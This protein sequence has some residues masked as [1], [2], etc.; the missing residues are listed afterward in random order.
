MVSSVLGALREIYGDSVPEPV[1]H[2]ITR[3][4]IDP[5]ALGSYSYVAVG[6]SHDDHDAMAG[7]VDGVLHFAGEATWGREPA[8]VHGALR[9]GH[10]AAERILGSPIFLAELTRG[11]RP[12]R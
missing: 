8:T 6:S 1:G 4:G 3:W 5:L 2:W 7:P 12:S 10:H 11:V 9:S